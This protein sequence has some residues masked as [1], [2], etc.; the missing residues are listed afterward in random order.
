M[1][2]AVLLL[3]GL[4]LLSVPHVSDAQQIPGLIAVGVGNMTAFESV[5][6]GANLN[7]G[8]PV[9]L[10]GAGLEFAST[11]GFC[12]LGRSGASGLLISG[13]SAIVRHV[14]VPASDFYIYLCLRQ[15]GLSGD[16]AAAILHGDFF[17]AA[18]ADEGPAAP[19]AADTAELEAV[20]KEAID[21]KFGR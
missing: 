9:A 5:A 16:F 1:K 11:V 18:T 4:L 3:A 14:T 6:A 19:A 17:D 15:S 7:A 13:S 12:G 8:T 20:V 2:S 10:W 21:R